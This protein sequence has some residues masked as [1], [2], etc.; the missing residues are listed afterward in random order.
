MSLRHLWAVTRKEVRHI[1]RDRMTFALVL[2]TPTLV[3]LLMAYALTVDIQH[4]PIA[5]L[6]RD[7]SALSRQFIQQITAGEDL[8][9]FAQVDSLDEVGDLLVKGAV[10]AAVVIH[11]R[12]LDGA[13]GVPGT[14]H[15]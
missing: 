5:V 7:R 15:H 3:L 12:G 8:D 13:A 10:R 4:V 14:D 9:L 6:D 1:F 11:P 2:L